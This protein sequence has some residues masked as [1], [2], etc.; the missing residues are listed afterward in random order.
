MTGS[1]R[2]IDF[3]NLPSAAGNFSALFLDYLTNPATV[4]EFFPLSYRNGRGFE[5]AINEVIASDVPRATLASVAE[6]QNE[7]FGAGQRS[8]Q[9]ASLLRRSTTF[10]VIT[11]QQVGLFGGPLYT[12]YKTITAIQLAARLKQKFPA[13]DFVPVF[14]LEGE[15]HDFDEMNKVSVPGHDA[16][17]SIVEYLPGGERPERNMGPVG[18]IVF[19]EWIS[20]AIDTLEGILP[21]TE[22]TPPLLATLR[23]CYQQGKTFNQAFASW[24][25]HLFHDAGLVFISLNHPKLKR[26]LSPMFERELSEFPA[27]SQLVITQSARLEQSYHAQIKTKSI[28]LFLFHKGGRYLIEPREHDFSLRGTRHFLTR[29]EL[30]AIA[31]EQPELLSP[32]VVLRPVAQDAIFPTVAYVAGPGEIAYQA[33]LQPVYSH[34]GVTRP[35]IYPRASVSI[36]EERVSRIM[37]KFGLELEEFFG[38][39]EALIAKVVRQLSEVK[40]DE[41]FDTAG[42]N[43]AAAL[44]EL[45]FGI[46]EVDPTL[47]GALDN[48]TSKITQSIKLLH[49]KTAGAQQRQHET[50]VRQIDRA[51]G[52]L[53]PDGTMQEREFN[54]VHFL[55]KYGPEFSGWIASQIESDGFKH[56]LLIR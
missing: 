2:W 8:V 42:K 21:K 4:A 43:V 24:M 26:L 20:K 5:T 41:L 38:D 10:A 34:F 40:I 32:N 35:V 1:Q 9:N 22:F 11:G 51:I 17:V 45:R 46:A 56:Q 13:N 7:S 28:N 37:E 25:S 29:D 6:E 48:T 30:L 16:G 18:E 23:S 14:W 47:L 49:D 19:D 50:S 52:S 44:T 27:V 3:R 53:L 39:R 12:V 33:Q 55:N 36:I 15:D 54:I 31:R